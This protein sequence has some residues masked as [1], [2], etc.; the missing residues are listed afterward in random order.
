VPAGP[1]PGLRRGRGSI[2]FARAAEARS[3]A[4]AGSTSRHRRAGRHRV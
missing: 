1:A 2:V 3:G 4:R